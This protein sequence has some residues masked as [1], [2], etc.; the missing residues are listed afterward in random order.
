MIA[1]L[2]DERGGGFEPNQSRSPAAR[3]LFLEPYLFSL[4]SSA[5]DWGSPR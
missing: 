2:Q 5:L 4:R 3:R 1:R